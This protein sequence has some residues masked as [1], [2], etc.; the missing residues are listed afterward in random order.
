MCGNREQTLSQIYRTSACKSTGILEGL[1][2]YDLM[3][4]HWVFKD[5]PI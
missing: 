5:I 3:T 4:A 2:L 1:P